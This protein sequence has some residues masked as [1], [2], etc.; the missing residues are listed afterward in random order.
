[1]LWCLILGAR[2]SRFCW[3]NPPYPSFIKGGDPKAPFVKGAARSAGGFDSAAVEKKL[4]ASKIKMVPLPGHTHVQTAVVS[5]ARAG[6][7]E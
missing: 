4:F 2:A 3:R 1:L 5:L 6:P 7:G